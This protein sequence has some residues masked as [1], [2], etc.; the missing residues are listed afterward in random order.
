MTKSC[1]KCGKDYE[2]VR[3]VPAHKRRTT[4]WCQECVDA[5][6][7]CRVCNFLHA[8]EDVTQDGINSRTKK[9]RYICAACRKWRDTRDERVKRRPDLY[10]ST[11]SSLMQDLILEIP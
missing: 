4:Y 7:Y 5:A 8:V 3:A 2:P 11:P 10:E 6:V 9:P 1:V